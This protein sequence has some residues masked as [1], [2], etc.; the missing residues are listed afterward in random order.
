MDG[1]ALVK[2][3]FL[4]GTELARAQVGW[5]LLPTAVIFADVEQKV[6]FA[7]TLLVRIMVVARLRL[8]LVEGEQTVR[9]FE[10]KGRFVHCVFVHFVHVKLVAAADFAAAEEGL[11]TGL[12]PIPLKHVISLI[13][14]HVINNY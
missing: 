4:V 5:Q 2:R 13:L 1:L 11:L 7:R 14:T 6:V 3:H 8:L 12:L 9:V 10:R